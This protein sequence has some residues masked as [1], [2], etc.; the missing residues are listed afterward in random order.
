MKLSKILEELEKGYI[1]DNAYEFSTEYLG[2]CKSYYSVL[3]STKA[4][5]TIA[6]LSILESALIKKADEYNN[7]SYDSLQMK[8]DRILAV[9]NKVVE[10]R[11]KMSLG[12]I[13]NY[14]I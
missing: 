1:C 3:K 9:C 13:D 6:T 14:A 8:R 7:P 2:R 5:P 12:K 11:R 10:M 4:N